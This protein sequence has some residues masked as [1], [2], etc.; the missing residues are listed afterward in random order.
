MIITKQR[1]SEQANPEAPA[2]FIRQAAAAMGRKGGKAGKG[3]PHNIDHEVAVAS[4]RAGAKIR[5]GKRNK[6]G[7]IPCE[8]IT[9]DG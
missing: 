6:A 7:N 1:A 8:G 9:L 5:W 4:G 3:V 2:D